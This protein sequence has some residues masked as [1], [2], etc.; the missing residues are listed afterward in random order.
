MLYFL[1]HR[2]EHQKFWPNLKESDY[3]SVGKGKGAGFNVNVPWNK[4]SKFTKFE[5]ETR[6]CSFIF[7]IHDVNNCESVYP[8]H[9]KQLL[10]GV[11][12][13]FCLLLRSHYDI[14]GGNEEQ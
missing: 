3:D 4:V 14:S 2:Y 6:K 8:N 5:A 12:A 13:S 10:I 11:C 1:W 9:L 7:C